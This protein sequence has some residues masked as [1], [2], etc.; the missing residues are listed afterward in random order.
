MPNF[1]AFLV[2]KQANAGNRFF[3]FFF[4]RLQGIDVEGVGTPLQNIPLKWANNINASMCILSF[5][6]T[7]TRIY[8]FFFFFLGSLSI[9]GVI[10]LPR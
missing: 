8:L 9:Q 5:C 10:Y 7:L 2:G 1:W 6:I 4:D 3:F